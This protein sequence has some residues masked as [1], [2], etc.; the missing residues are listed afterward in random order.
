[1]KK[2]APGIDKMCS[3]GHLGPDCGAMGVQVGPKVHFETI[4]GCLWGAIGKLCGHFFC[5]CLAGSCDAI[6]NMFPE[7]LFDGSASLLGS[8]G[9]IFT[10][11]AVVGSGENSVLI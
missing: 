1:M 6:S 7:W 9:I 11:L 10:M 3:V 8:L 2:I 4:P 5:F